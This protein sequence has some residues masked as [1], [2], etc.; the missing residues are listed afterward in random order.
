MLK[1][2]AIAVIGALNLTVLRSLVATPA[3]ILT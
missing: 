3:A 1:P 2:P